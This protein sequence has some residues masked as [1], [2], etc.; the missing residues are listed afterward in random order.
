MQRFVIGNDIVVAWSLSVGRWWTHNPKCVSWRLVLQDVPDMERIIHV[1]D[2]RGDQYYQGQSSL[3][4][5]ETCAGTRNAVILLRWENLCS[6][7]AGQRR[8]NRWMCQTTKWVRPSRIRNFQPPWTLWVNVGDVM[9]RHILNIFQSTLM[10]TLVRYTLFWNHR[11]L[12]YIWLKTP[13]TGCP[14]TFHPP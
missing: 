6:A 1:L 14:A 2:N 5:A 7:P 3:K 13:K 12:L 11:L 9:L 10:R 4:Q 8:R